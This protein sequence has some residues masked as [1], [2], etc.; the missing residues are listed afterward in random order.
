M[1][2]PLLASGPCAIE[3]RYNVRLREHGDTLEAICP[4]HE[5]SLHMLLFPSVKVRHAQVLAWLVPYQ[6]VYTIVTPGLHTAVLRTAIASL[7]RGKSLFCVA[8]I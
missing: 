7:A 5:P 4:L 3:A 8:R 6:Q 1:S 2:I